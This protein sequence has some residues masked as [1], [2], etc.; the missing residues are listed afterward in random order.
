MSR[1]DEMYERGSPPWDIGEPQA[2]FVELEETGQIT[3]SVLDAGC[4]TGELALY[5]SGRGHEVWGIDFARIAL[6]RARQKSA[7]RGIPVVFEYLDALDM[8]ALGRTFDTVVDCGLFHSFDD[9][10]RIRY[11]RSLAAVLRPGGVYHMMCFSELETRDGG[12]RRVTQSEIRSA[13]QDGWEV[14]SIQAKRFGG[15]TFPATG[16]GGGARG[17]LSRIRRV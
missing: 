10:D 4:G 3:G 16:D 13:F 8:K 12:P 17:W 5:L 9:N 1:F 11:V 6:E 2:V 7:E 15:R 14:E